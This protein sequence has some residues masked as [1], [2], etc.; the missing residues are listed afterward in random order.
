[1]P[2]SLFLGSAFATQ[3]REKPVEPGVD[4]SLSTIK[5]DEEKEYDDSDIASLRSP[6]APA[7]RPWYRRWTM[8]GA[9]E[10][11]V[12]AT[13]VWFRVVRS[14]PADAEVKSHAEWENHSLAFVQT[15][16]NHGIVD[17]TI[18]LLGIAVVINALYVLLG[19]FDQ[20]LL[21]VARLLILASATFYYGFGETGNTSPATLFDAYDLL[22]STLGKGV[23]SRTAHMACL[24]TQRSRR[25]ALR[26]RAPRLRPVVL[27]HR[28]PRRT[29]RLRGLPPLARLRTSFPHLTNEFWC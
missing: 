28:H 26:A 16:L 2:H 17:M 4:D 7:H 15:H 3:E 22:E 27:H 6:E 13:K 21:T 29:D 8:R 24:L 14:V 19:I 12:R 25:N 18:S 1:M 11:T 23:S 10:R 5:G 20:V 9:Y